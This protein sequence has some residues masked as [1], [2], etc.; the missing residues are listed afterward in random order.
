MHHRK[1]QRELHSISVRLTFILAVLIAAIYVG[2]RLVILSRANEPTP[3]WWTSLIFPLVFCLAMVEIVWS[4]R[5]FQELSPAITAIINTTRRGAVHRW[6]MRTI[7]KMYN[8]TA[9]LVTALFVIPLLITVT[10]LIGW[11]SWL[12]SRL[13][14][15]Y[16]TV[17]Q[18]ILLSAAASSQWPFANIS[19]FVSRLS[20]KSLQVNF[21]AHPRDSIM[22]FGPF[23]LKIALGGLIL[24]TLLA[25]AAYSSPLHI[26][27]SVHLMFIIVYLWAGYWFFSTQGA[28]HK[29]M[30]EQKRDN[31]KIVSERLMSLLRIVK[32]DP[33]PEKVRDFEQLKVLYEEFRKL[34]EWPFRTE[35]VLTLATG[36]IVPITVTVIQLVASR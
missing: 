21:Y 27:V 9:C 20:R 19:I 32:E 24:T 5:G 25:V 6:Y 17:F 35:T 29:C 22:S 11:N 31:L 28:I 3:F 2:G 15:R 13:L 10:H 33:S 30:V 23:L 18:T 4:K 14:R 1:V 34:P 26:P 8:P 12:Q 7:G 36:I 16:D